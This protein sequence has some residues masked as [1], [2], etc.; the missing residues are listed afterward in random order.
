MFFLVIRNSSNKRRIGV[1]AL[2]KNLLT[3]LSQ[4]GRIFEGGAY[5]S[6]YGIWEIRKLARLETRMT[7][8]KGSLAL[9]VEWPQGESRHLVCQHVGDLFSSILVPV[10]LVLKCCSRLWGRELLSRNTPWHVE[11]A[12]NQEG[13]MF[14]LVS[15]DNFLH[16]TD[17]KGV[18]LLPETTLFHINRPFVCKLWSN[19]KVQNERS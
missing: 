14:S 13:P 3:F 7:L 12:Q 11:H 5:S 18:T 4:M 19:I 6:K 9:K 15:S 17:R 16:M 8:N 10:L 1:A 2:I